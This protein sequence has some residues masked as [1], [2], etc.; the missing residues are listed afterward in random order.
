MVPLTTSNIEYVYHNQILYKIDLGSCPH[1]LIVCS[2]GSKKGIHKNGQNVF[3]HS[4]WVSGRNQDISY[5]YIYYIYTYNYICM[6]VYL[7]IH[8]KSQCPIPPS[9]E[10]SEITVPLISQISRKP[11]KGE[12]FGAIKPLSP[13]VDSPLLAWKK[14]EDRDIDIEADMI[15]VI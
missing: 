15:C 2:Q 3:P 4:L 7:H 12:S 8:H 14:W 11:S 1:P 9:K 10:V 13:Q 5:I 6:Y